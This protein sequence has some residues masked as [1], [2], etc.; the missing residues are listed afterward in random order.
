MLG[1]GCSN[2]SECGPNVRR[3]QSCGCDL[4][5]FEELCSKC[6]KARHAEID[7][8]RSFLESIR[9]FGASPLRQQEVNARD[10]AVSGQLLWRIALLLAIGVGFDWHC[11]FGWFR[12][13]Y[14]PFSAPVLCQ[15]GLIVASCSACAVLAVCLIRRAGWRDACYFF[16]IFSVFVW[17]WL[18]AGWIADR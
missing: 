11:G 1:Q 13:R 9:Q 2:F 18:W 6:F 16:S 15:T 12:G 8:P 14:S 4:P 10:T 7:R 5:G 17:N 3:C